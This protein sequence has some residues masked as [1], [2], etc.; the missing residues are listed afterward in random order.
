MCYFSGTKKREIIM[1]ELPEIIAENLIFLRKKSGMTQLEFG[2]KFNYT[3]KTVSRW[4]NGSIM[5]SIDVLKQIADYYG[6][7]V[8]YIVNEHHSASE[9]SRSLNKSVSKRDKSI[10]LALIITVIWTVAMVIYVAN[11][12]KIGLDVHENLY[13]LAFLWSV[14]VSLIVTGI[15]LKRWFGNIKWAYICLSGFVWTTLTA[16]YVMF[17]ML[18]QNYW[19][20]YFIGVPLQIAIVLLSYLRSH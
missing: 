6:V 1:K 20:L 11:V 3:D 18:Y 16:A 2:E 7:S 8:D 13:W 4:E 10:L 15:Y 14:P 17:L 19:Y 5:P 9:L 12:Y